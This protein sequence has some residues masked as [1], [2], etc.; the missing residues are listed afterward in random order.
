MLYRLTAATG[1]HRGEILGLR[2]DDIHF[3]SGR[4]E[5]TQAL[6]SIGY[7]M[8][9]TRLKT[10]TRRRNVTLDPDTPPCS[11]TGAANENLSL[12]HI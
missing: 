2:W 3:G 6:I 7:E 9:F 8:V 5:I 1:M 12:I 10:R 11:Q 4:I